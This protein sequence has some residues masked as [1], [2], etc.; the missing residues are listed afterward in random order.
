MGNDHY[1][2]LI[3]N[4]EDIVSSG[5]TYE[6]AE[7]L[8]LAEDVP[9][10]PT[11]PVYVYASEAKDN[12]YY[13]TDPKIQGELATERGYK[14]QNNGEPVFHVYTRPVTGETIPLY[15]WFADNNHFYTVHPSGERASWEDGVYK[16][17]LGH[18]YPK[19]TK[20]KGSIK[21]LY[22]YYKK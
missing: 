16:G 19:D 1:Y 14:P 10:L 18:V 9:E 7:C 6:G 17:I 21:P 15:V 11:S 20:P 8:V 4:E 5:Y 13:T 22:R 3:E 12:H 2:S